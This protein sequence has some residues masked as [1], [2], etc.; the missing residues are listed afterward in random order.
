MR[1]DIVI[2]ILYCP[3]ACVYHVVTLGVFDKI[4][5][6]VTRALVE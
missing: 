5:G 6:V 4:F 1:K 3:H 2:L